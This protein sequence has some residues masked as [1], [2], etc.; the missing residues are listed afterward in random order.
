MRHWSRTWTTTLTR[1]KWK[2]RAATAAAQLKTT[3]PPPT[4]TRCCAH[5][6][7]GARADRRAGRPCAR[8][9][10][11]RP[12]QLC[13]SGGLCRRRPACR[14]Q[15]HTLLEKSPDTGAQTAADRPPGRASFTA[16]DEGGGWKIS[17]LAVCCRRRDGR[18]CRLEVLARPRT[19]GSA[20]R[21]DDVV[22]LKDLSALVRE[23]A[24]WI[25]HST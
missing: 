25:I 2:C 9:S 17:E 1:W 15:G 18:G 22:E 6:G 16:R 20:R 10:I 23:S 24:C 11:L 4:K 19:D 3:S 7:A 12:C 14:W 8:K 13:W 21:Y 5:S